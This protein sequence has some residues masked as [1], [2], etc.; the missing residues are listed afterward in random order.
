MKKQEEYIEIIDDNPYV[1]CEI[2]GDEFLDSELFDF[3][4]QTVCKSCISFLEAQYDY[5]DDDD[6][7]DD[8]DDYDYDYDDEDYEQ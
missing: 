6:Y 7:D 4:N 3:K 5:Y 1:E 2:C 8:Y